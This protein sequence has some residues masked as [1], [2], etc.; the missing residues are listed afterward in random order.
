MHLTGLGPGVYRDS[1]DPEKPGAYPGRTQ[2]CRQR[3]KALVAEAPEGQGSGTQR[4]RVTL[5]TPK[6]LRTPR[7]RHRGSG[8]TKNPLNLL[9]TRRD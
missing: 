8:V 3:P 2:N 7:T 5:G 4:R 1:I 6:S 9:P